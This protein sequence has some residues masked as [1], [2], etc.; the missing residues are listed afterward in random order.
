MSVLSVF[1]DE[2]GEVSVP[3]GYYVLTLVF[4][5]QDQD[6]SSQL[7]KIDEALRLAS[8]PNERAIHSGPIIRREDEYHYMDLET[9]RLLFDKILTFARITKV[10]HKSFVFRKH[11]YPDRVSIAG[12]ISREMTLFFKN[13]LNFFQSFERIFVYY[14]NGQA[15][16]TSIVNSIFNANFFDVD[17]RKVTPSD[18]RLFQAADMLC[19]LEMINAKIEDNRLSNSEEMFFKGRR[20]LIKD[21]IRTMQSMRFQ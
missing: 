4:H 10:R 5:D 6:I 13:N 18:Y 7:K 16:I 17:I 15:E 1:I 21:Y 14:D 2:S 19:T 8:L 20:R 9:R 11:E 3:T 12:R